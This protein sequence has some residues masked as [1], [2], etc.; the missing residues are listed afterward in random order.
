MLQQ[1]DRILLRVPQLEAA[2]RFYRDV[3]GLKIIRQDAR[4]AS[5][6]L[7][8]S[9]TE[10]VLHTDEN[11]PADALYY[12]VENV[13]ELY[14]NREKLRLNFVSAPVAVSRGFRG[15]IKDPFGNVML[16][17]DRSA[18]DA[19]QSTVEPAKAPGMLFADAPT[20][21]PT[22][23]EVLIKVYTEINRTADDLPYTPHFETL[24]QT[25]CKA[26]DT[27]PTRQE[28]W[29]H[30]L[31]LR[32]KK[33]NLPKIGEARSIPPPLEPEEKARLLELMHK[34]LGPSIGKRDRLPYSKEFDLLVDTFN[35]TQR[36]HI[37]PHIVWRLV[38]TMAK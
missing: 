3:L 4:L 31:N 29:R 1:V 5:L 22:K 17:L 18:E 28:T 27:P 32:K 33:G 8:D 14:Q 6:K 37:S 9:P 13:R 2:L 36:R 38:A 35:K 34:V 12:R 7:A 20:R 19:G 24:Y 23:A 15:T 21:Q 26:F 11:L 16:L 25:Y 30:L 10:L